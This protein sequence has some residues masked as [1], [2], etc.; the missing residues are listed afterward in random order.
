LPHAL[1]LKL[2]IGFEENGDK[3]RE[4]PELVAV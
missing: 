2:L 4:K 3:K 1:A